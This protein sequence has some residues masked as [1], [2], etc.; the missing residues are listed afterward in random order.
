MPA[1]SYPDDLLYHPEHDWARIDG[2][3]ATFGITWYAQDSL[4]DVVVFLPPAV[5]Q[6]VTAGA[7]YG[8]LES[9]KAVSGIVT[10]LSRRGHRGQ[11]GGRGR[12]R[13]RQR[14]SLRRRLADPRAPAQARRSQAGCSTSTPTA[15]RSPEGLSR[16]EHDAPSR[17]SAATRAARS[18]TSSP[19]ACSPP[20]GRDGL[21]A[22][23]D[24]AARR[25]LAAAPA[26][27]RAARQR[28]APREPGRPGDARR[29]RR[30]LHHHGADRVPA[31]VRLEHD[32]HDD[33]AARDR[34]ARDARARDRR[35]ARGA[36]AASSRRAP[37]AATVA[38]RAS[39]S[40]TCPASPTSS[41]CRS[42]SPGSARVSVD[43]AY[44]GMWY[45][46]ADARALGF[47]IEPHG[48][49]RPLDRRR[50]DPRG[51]ARAARV[52][53]PRESRAS[54]ASASCRSPSPGRASAR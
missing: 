2:D 37:P 29:L 25:R 16:C 39:S 26:P 36:R 40:R 38:A 11:P 51:R 7:E 49:A 10:P 46:I 32:L 12:A 13:A 9:V 21:R 8:E 4:G 14:G 6:Q 1:E 27:A 35:A 50:A 34:H 42:R 48:G 5:G 20:R 15:Q 52:H 3:E 45:A 17:S 31:D 44:G 24:A 41:T 30:G 18:A 47:A 43:V 54:R 22:D 23:A 53:A 28:G 33:R 19:A